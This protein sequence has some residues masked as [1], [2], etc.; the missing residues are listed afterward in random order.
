MQDRNSAQSIE[1]Y[2]SSTKSLQHI[3]ISAALFPAPPSVLPQNLKVLHISTSDVCSVHSEERSVRVEQIISI[4]STSCQGLRFLIFPM[5][6]S[7][8]SKTI[9]LISEFKE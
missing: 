5:Y 3:R 2:F 1:P 8:T 6:L 4:A 9:T 7:A